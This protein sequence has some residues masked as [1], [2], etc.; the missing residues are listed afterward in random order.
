MSPRGRELPVQLLPPRFQ[1]RNPE[2]VPPEVLDVAED[3]I[4]SLGRQLGRDC[5]QQ[6]Q[7]RGLAAQLQ[8]SLILLI[9]TQPADP[10]LLRGLPEAAACDFSR[11][12][13]DVCAGARV[14]LEVYPF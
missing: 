7:L 13:S 10:F 6:K 14:P 4:V 8:N 5:Q 2:L 3:I 1:F 12:V 9:P 11:Q